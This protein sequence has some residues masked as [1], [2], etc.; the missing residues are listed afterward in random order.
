MKEKN[1]RFKLAKEW[2]DIGEEKFNFA[3]SSFEEFNRFYPQIC[4]Q[5]QQTVEKYL[6]GFL[7]LHTKKVPRIHDLPELVKICSKI[8][9]EFSK[10]LEKASILSQFYIIT[11]Y[12][13]EYPPAGKKEAE[14][15]LII[16]EEIISFIKKIVRNLN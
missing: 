12:P 9:K 3:Q 15:C 16:A 10:F 7:V 6:K 14:E 11:R 5:C 13:L 2:F 4:F 1:N 8:N